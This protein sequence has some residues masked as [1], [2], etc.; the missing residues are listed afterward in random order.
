MDF[1]DRFFPR[2]KREA[3]LEEFI[4][5]RY[6]GTSVLKYSL[7]LNK[8][9]T[10]ASSLVSNSRDEMNHFVVGVSDDLVEECR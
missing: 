1:L 3:K 5:L 2:E 8:L 7:I 10:Y 6:G 4:N 9:S